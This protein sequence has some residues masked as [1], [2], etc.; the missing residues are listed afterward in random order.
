MLRVPLR[1]F[2]ETIPTDENTVSYE[3]PE[4]EIKGVS[5]HPKGNYLMTYTCGVCTKRQSRSFSK[6]AY[7]AGVVI[8]RCEECDNLHLIADNLGWFEDEK[9]N[10]ETLAERNNQT[11]TRLTPNTEQAA[12][13]IQ[14]LQKAKPATVKTQEIPSDLFDDEPV[15][16]SNN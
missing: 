1:Y 13:L 6:Q 15:K 2:A 9:V 3:L 4:G 8:I 12:K 11:V 7:H 16:K 10:I 5:L 14:K